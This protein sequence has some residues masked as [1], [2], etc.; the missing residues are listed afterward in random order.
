DGPP[1]EDKGSPL[2]DVADRILATGH[3]LEWWAFA[4]K[5]LLPPDETLSKAVQWTYSEIQALSDSQ[6]KR[7]YTFLTHAGRALSLWR[8]KMPHEV[9]KERTEQL[10]KLNLT[11]ADSDQPDNKQ[12]EVSVMGEVR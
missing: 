10:A 2:G 6:V 7:F 5:E 1:S 4:P 9:W 11:D 12:F 3:A 8:G